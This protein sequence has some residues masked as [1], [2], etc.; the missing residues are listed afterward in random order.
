MEREIPFEVTTPED[1]VPPFCGARAFLYS[2]LGAG[3]AAATLRWRRNNA[4]DPKVCHCGAPGT[5]RVRDHGCTVV[6]SVP[7]YWWRCDEHKTVPLTV[8]WVDGVP[9]SY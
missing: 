1:T 6:G 9:Q 5:V 8:A 4:T 3:D 2:W 7:P